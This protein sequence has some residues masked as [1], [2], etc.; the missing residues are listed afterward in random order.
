M[1]PSP[2]LLL[3]ASMRGRLGPPMEPNGLSICG[4]LVTVMS[5]SGTPWT[6]ACKASL[7]FTISQSLLQLMSMDS[8]MPSN[9]LTLCHPLL[10]LASIF[11]SIRVSAY[12]LSDSPLLVDCLGAL[13][14]SHSFCLCLIFYS[15]FFLILSNMF[16][17]SIFFLPNS[18]TLYFHH[19][20]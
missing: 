9:H 12:P 17:V 11:P 6:V 20:I 4:C 1:V 5:N 16:T 3:S 14:N 2:P 15:S 10:L 19:S 8:V 18:T 7:S 13:N